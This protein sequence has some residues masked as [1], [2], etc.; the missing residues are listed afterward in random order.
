LGV[1]DRVRRAAWGISGRLIASYVLVTLAVVVLVEAIVLGYQ[2]P[3]LVNDTQLQ[4]QLAATAQ[5]YSKQ[6]VGDYRNGIPAGTVL[7]ETGQPARP[8]HAQPASDG[9]TLVVPAIPGPLKSDKAVTAMVAIAQ[10][11]TILASSV[12]A[13]Y[14]PGQPAAGLLPKAAAT[15]LAAGPTRP[16]AVSKGSTQRG[17]VWWTVVPA[18]A[19]AAQKLPAGAAGSF[20]AF[21][22]MQAPVSSGSINPIRAWS[23]LRHQS[24][25]GPLLTAAYVLVIAIVPVGVLFGLLA[26]RRLVRRVR[27]LEQATVAVADGDYTV[28]LPT[29]GRDEVGSLEAN[30]TA[31]THQLGSALSAER[32]RATGDA[33]AAERARIAREIHDAISQ[34]LFGL[35]MI[36][37]GMRRADPDHPQVRAIERITEEALRDMQALLLELRPA[38]LGASRLAPALQRICVAYRDRLG[39]TIDADIDDITVPGPVE[40]ALLRIAQEACTNAVRHGNARRLALHMTRRDGHVELSVRDTGTGFDPSAPHAGSGLQHIHDRVAELGGTVEIDSA[41]GAGTALTVRVPAP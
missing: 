18:A 25:A 29:S 41:P 37:A 13:W 9:A 10:D 17:H 21:L 36:A 31:M 16:R 27:R 8:G 3:R 35:R 22:Y 23:E 26:S 24:G 30:F 15:A 19:R 40:H 20:P 28:T 4:A 2:A 12:P 14:P 6:V 39:V 1:L 34:H 11:G 5:I 33:R 32:E 7:G 38:G